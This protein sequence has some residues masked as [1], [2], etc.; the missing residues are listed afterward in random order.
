MVECIWKGE[1]IYLL[2]RWNAFIPLLDSSVDLDAYA[3]PHSHAFRL[4]NKHGVRLNRDIL[5]QFHLAPEQSLQRGLRHRQGLLELFQ[6]LANDDHFLDQTELHGV[7]TQ[8]HVRPLGAVFQPG[9]GQL[10]R[11]LLFVDGPDEAIYVLFRLNN[12]TLNL[13]QPK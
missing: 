13:D 5:F 2:H 12:L 4:V 10:H 6:R 11:S 8:F 9:V 1:Y 3:L 7:A